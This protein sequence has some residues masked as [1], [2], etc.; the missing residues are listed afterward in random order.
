MGDVEQALLSYFLTQLS[1]YFVRLID[2][3]GSLGGFYFANV[4][5]RGFATAK[6]L[7]SE[8]PCCFLLFLSLNFCS[9]LNNMAGRLLCCIFLSG[10]PIQ[11]V[12]DT[13]MTWCYHLSCYV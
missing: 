7:G 1:Y 5:P 3:R 8:S 2:L 4:F 9:K 10:F 13:A 11:Q 12:T 6:Y